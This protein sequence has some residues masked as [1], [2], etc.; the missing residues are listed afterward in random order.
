V[1]LLAGNNAVVVYHNVEDR[2]SQVPGGSV[3]VP[4]LILQ[5]NAAGV[6]DP[7]GSGRRLRWHRYGMVKIT[8]GSGKQATLEGWVASGEQEG[9]NPC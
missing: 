5:F 7:A 4:Q 3:E 8:R 6:I 1:E 9:V 2:S